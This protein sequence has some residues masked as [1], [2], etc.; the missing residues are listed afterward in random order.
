MIGAP[1]LLQFTQSLRHHGVGRFLC[2]RGRFGCRLL[3]RKNTSFDAHGVL[4]G[5]IDSV[6]AII[7]FPDASRG[8]VD[9]GEQTHTYA[10]S[11]DGVLEVGNDVPAV[12]PPGAIRLEPIFNVV[13]IPLAKD[14]APVPLCRI[15]VV[16]IAAAA[17]GQRHGHHAQEEEHED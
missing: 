3:T 5:I 12:T 15:Y 16:I 7:I 9:V 14:L 4:L 6:V 13:A 10:L 11:I 2:G 1:T 8:S 17:R